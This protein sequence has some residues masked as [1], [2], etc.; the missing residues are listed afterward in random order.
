ML[1]SEGIWMNPASPESLQLLIERP[2]SFLLAMHSFEIE[3]AYHMKA[4]WVVHRK[5][6]LKVKF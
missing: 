5:I 4:V 1:E 2:T 6:H 3:A